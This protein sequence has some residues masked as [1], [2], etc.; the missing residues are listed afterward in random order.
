M[1]TEVVEKV[2]VVKVAE[3]DQ[4]LQAVVLAAQLVPN[5]Y[6]QTGMTGYR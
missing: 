6:Q 3:E 5:Q 2:R 1:F 4:M